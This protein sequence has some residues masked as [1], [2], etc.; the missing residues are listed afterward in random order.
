IASF[1]KYGITYTTEAFQ[2]NI[3]CYV[4]SSV[5]LNKA[6]KALVIQTKLEVCSV[7]RYI[8]ES[9]WNLVKACN[10]TVSIIVQN[11]IV[12]WHSFSIKCIMWSRTVKFIPVIKITVIYISTCLTNRLICQLLVFWK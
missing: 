11:N 7:L 1:I 3:T 8:G 5:E 2:T 9:I 10:Y 6:T 4:R 12:T